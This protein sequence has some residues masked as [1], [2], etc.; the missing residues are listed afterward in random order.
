MSYNSGVIRLVIS[1][2]PRATRSADLKLLAQLLPGLYSTQSYYHYLLK[3]GKIHFAKVIFTL[4][5]Y[6]FTN[7][8]RSIPEKPHTIIYKFT[9]M[10]NKIHDLI[11]LQNSTTTDHPANAF[12]LQ[13]WKFL[14]CREPSYFWSSC[15]NYQSAEYLE[16]QTRVNKFSTLAGYNSNELN[17]YN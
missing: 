16:R 8:L 14:R 17:K 9:P 5:K 11:I 3:I 7:K 2:W 4:F 6:S 13:M 12:H 15:M 10:T 1:N